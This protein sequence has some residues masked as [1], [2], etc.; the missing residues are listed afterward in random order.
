MKKTIILIS[1]FLILSFISDVFISNKKL[2]TL[3]VK[4]EIKLKKELFDTNCLKQVSLHFEDVFVSN[5][6]TE[7][8]YKNVMGTVYHAEKSQ[9]DD[10]PLITADNSLIDTARVND[11]RWVALSRD[12]IERKFTDKRGNKH[13][14]KG[15]IKLGD[16]IWI[17]YDKES[18]W[19]HSHPDY[20]PKDLKRTAR[21]DKKYE[22]LKAKYEQIRG[23]WI[24]HDVMG[25]QYTRKNR[26]G[27][28]MLDKD[29]NKQIVKIHN[30]IDFL[31][32]PSS[33]M[34]D[35]WNRNIIIAKR[36]VVKIT[37]PLYAM[38]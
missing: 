6:T 26:K 7:I 4:K 35:V 20:N 23:Y 13:V 16:T 9:C 1:L 19:K 8:L 38:N 5:V 11:L 14:W 10:T 29:G 3:T 28:Y 36:R 24:V 32:H 34:L 30:A 37:S 25:I 33:G 22:H 21:Q 17:D 27:E 2:D 15:K 31:Q 12:L 18:L